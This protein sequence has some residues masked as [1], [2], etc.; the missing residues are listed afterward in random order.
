MLLIPS[1]FLFGK[2][3]FFETDERR[4]L[5]KISHNA[6]TI[7]KAP[8]KKGTNGTF[9]AVTYNGRE[10]FVYLYCKHCN[11]WLTPEER[12]HTGSHHQDFVAGRECLPFDHSAM[13][14]I[15][16]I[17]L[18]AGNDV[19]LRLEGNVAPQAN[20]GNVE[21]LGAEDDDAPQDVPAEIQ[22]VQEVV[23][24]PPPPVAFNI[25]HPPVVAAS[26]AVVGDYSGR[27]IRNN[28]GVIDPY[29][30]AIPV[31]K[32]KRAT[33]RGRTSPTSVDENINNNQ[34][35]ND[36]DINDDDSNDSSKENEFV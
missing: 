34:D 11:K 17:M 22:I 35:D 28:R 26:N 13:I 20:H 19:V 15:Q 4:P 14:I 3:Y 2:A 32:R 1:S 7:W 6:N 10:V 25:P 30:P 29:V 5:A 9:M 33:K 23:V 18:E 12:G 24:V 31:P 36:E 21:M 8:P 27:P 16:K